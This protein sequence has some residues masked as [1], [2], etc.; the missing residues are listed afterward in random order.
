MEAMGDE[1]FQTFINEK[2]F[3]NELS[4]AFL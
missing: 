4:K 2:A 3:D 1:R